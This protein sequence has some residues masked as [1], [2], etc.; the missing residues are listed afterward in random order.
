MLNLNIKPVPA[1]K[2]KADEEADRMKKQED[3]SASNVKLALPNPV[4]AK[5]TATVKGKSRFDPI[6]TTPPQPAA[7]PLAT[8]PIPV[9]HPVS[10]PS[11]HPVT[12]MGMPNMPNFPPQLN[13]PG[14]PP[15]LM[16]LPLMPMAPNPYHQPPPGVPMINYGGNQGLQMFPPGGQMFPIQSPVMIQGMPTSAAS[17]SAPPMLNQ[18]QMPSAVTH[19]APQPVQNPADDEEEDGYQE[20]NTATCLFPQGRDSKLQKNL[21]SNPDHTFI[22]N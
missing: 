4:K 15:P 19:P 3:N 1:T 7:A 22:G 10:L 18:P 14:H 9:R 13:Y 16:S 21:E 8:N 17:I 5:A 20:N 11:A 2:A 12:P 6:S